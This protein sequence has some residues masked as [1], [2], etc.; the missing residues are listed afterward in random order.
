MKAK[1]RIASMELRAIREM[2][3]ESPPP[4]P[5]GASVREWFAGLALACPNLMQGVAPNKRATEAVRL[6]DEL[7][8][9]LLAPRVPTVESM[10]APTPAELTQWESD[11]AQKQDAKARQNRETC[12]AV[13]KPLKKNK[14][15][16]FD[17]ILPPPST[18]SGR[19]TIP[20]PPLKPGNPMLG[21]TRYS[22][23]RDND[24]EC[25]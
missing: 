1:K 15:I 6:A 16:K 8:R 11:I 21:N 3:V 2:M 22:S 12:P 14:T 17:A 24:I 10:A 13:K 25:D 19:P 20:P 9:A 5:P 4:P 7:L 23:I 18:T